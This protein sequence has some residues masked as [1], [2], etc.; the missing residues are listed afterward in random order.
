[1]RVLRHGL[2]STYN[3][4]TVR[5]DH[6]LTNGLTFLSHYTYS[7]TTT[8]R[9]Q[10]DGPIDDLS[11]PAWDWNLHLGRGEAIF[12]HPHRF[13]AAATWDLPFG[14]SLTGIA[15]GALYGWRVSG[16]YVAES[17]DALTV[18]NG[19]S[20]ARDF[21]PEMPNV[22]G[23]P[24]DGPK[25]T[26]EYFNTGAFADPGQDVKGNARPGNPARPGDQ[27]PRSVD[28][29]DVR[30][31]R[32]EAAVPGGSLQCAEPRAVAIPGHRFQHRRRQHIRSRHRRARRAGSCSS[33]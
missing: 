15:R 9:Y 17:G 23:D 27:Q 2:T 33:V 25:T 5:V 32:D 28:R 16:V 31:R 14:E 19:Q 4:G 30:H 11:Q 3:A 1:M 29:Q 21:E 26:L 7:K 13:V 24:N 20:S 8:D 10:T 22:V 18:F 12:S 6:R